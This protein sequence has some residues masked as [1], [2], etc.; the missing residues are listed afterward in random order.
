M[1]E[2]GIG[3]R[4]AAAPLPF[5]IALC[6]GGTGR[7]AWWTWP[8][9]DVP[10]PLE[11]FERCRL[12]TRGR[13]TRSWSSWPATCRSAARER[14]PPFWISYDDL[15]ARC[16]EVG[17]K[18]TPRTIATKLLKPLQAACL[19]K[20][21]PDLSALII[22]K[23]KPRGDFGNLLR[24]ADGW[25]EPYVT[26]ELT[27]GRR[28]PVLVQGVPDRPRLRRLARRPLLLIQPTRREA[29]SMA[30]SPETSR[31]V[32]PVIDDQ[33]DPSRRMVRP[34]VAPGRLPRHDP[35]PDGTGV[36]PPPPALS[37]LRVHRRD[38]LHACARQG[39]APVRR[40]AVADLA[41]HVRQRSRGRRRALRA[42]RA[43]GSAMAPGSSPT[44]SS[45]R[46]LLFATMA[47]CPILPRRSWLLRSFRAP[48]G[49]S[50]S[51]GKPSFTARPTPPS[52]GSSTA[53][54]G[55]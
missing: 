7:E 48:T 18:E 33:A 54:T 1:A 38:R 53:A 46:S 12:K 55:P 20:G 23:P 17:V 47:T 14:R 9:V 28:R 44:S 2:A 24:P 29:P 3:P 6:T 37:V 21:V 42:R 32:G 22:A 10:A 43:S 26:K 30:T 41:G 50:T 27:D 25:W 19:E 31:A 35:R 4:A 13:S 51:A 49:R 45:S 16:K 40:A 8:S 34:L 36:P 52:F 15:C 5:A 39:S 11:D